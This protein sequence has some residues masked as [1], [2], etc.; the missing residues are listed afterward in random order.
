MKNIKKNTAN[1]ILEVQQWGE[2]LSDAD[3]MAVTGGGLTDTLLNGVAS[4]N[5]GIGN[6]GTPTTGAVNL[7]AN[8]LTASGGYLSGVGNGLELGLQAVN[9][10]VAGTASQV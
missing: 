9:A 8:T 5:N 7:V 3:L 2:E 1:A 6:G 10:T 4:A